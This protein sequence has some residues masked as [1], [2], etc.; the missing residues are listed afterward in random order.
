MNAKTS[1]G[2]GTSI[3]S[4]NATARRK[5]NI[6]LAAKYR[7]AVVSFGTGAPKTLDASLREAIG[8]AFDG[9]PGK[10]LALL[11]GV[12]EYGKRRWPS[13]S[14]VSEVLDEHN[15]SGL[16][17]AFDESGHK[18]Y[19]A[20]DAKKGLVDVALIQS[21]TT[22]KNAIRETVETLVDQSQQ[23]GQRTVN[24]GGIPVGLLICGENN[25]LA[26]RQSEDNKVHMRHKVPG[27]LFGHV[28][29]IFNGAHTTMGNWGKLEKRFQ[30]L[31]TKKRLCFYATNCENEGWGRS[32]LRAYY[33]GKLIADS[34]RVLSGGPGAIRLEES[35]AETGGWVMLSMDISGDKLLRARHAP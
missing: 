2:E 35:T 10:R 14:L 28:P 20:H 17:E 26:N 32:S 3:T 21:F 1:S 31:S 24:V 33:N 7:I 34:Q 8:R 4:R 30:H 12:Q 22:S 27:T 13:C 15:A 23:G 9:F 16:F 18:A 25:V 5:P 11:P 19:R 6:D 29:I